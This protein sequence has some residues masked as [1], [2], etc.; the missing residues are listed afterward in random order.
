MVIAI[1]SDQAGFSLKRALLDALSE[2]GYEYHDFGCHSAE[3]V[4][5]PDIAHA[6]SEAVAAGRFERAILVC[7]TGAGM[8]VAAN[9]T[10]GVRAVVANDTFTAHQAR[11]HLDAQVLCLGERIVGPGLARDIVKTYL[12]ASFEGGRH[13]RRV[14]KIEKIE[15]VP[16]RPAPA[17]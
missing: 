12:T 13:E 15:A 7:G 9:K 16:S 3:S 17:S 6:V 4:D 10:P 14:N 1:G 5:Y 2:L 11:E 8:A